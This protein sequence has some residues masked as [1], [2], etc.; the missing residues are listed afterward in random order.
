M[1][2]DSRKAQHSTVAQ[3]RASTFFTFKPA[4]AT[5]AGDQ[6]KSPGGLTALQQ[7]VRAGLR[8]FT[9]AATASTL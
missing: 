5:G 1:Y 7:K 3:Q 6:P 8:G 2:R 4:T 9:P